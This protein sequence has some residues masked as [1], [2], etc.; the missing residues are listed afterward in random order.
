MWSNDC[1]EK[2]WSSVSRP[3]AWNMK[4]LTNHFLLC[5]TSRSI[6]FCAFEI[7]LS[8][9]YRCSSQTFFSWLVLLQIMPV[10]KIDPKVH[11]KSNELW[12]WTQ[13]IA[14]LY[15]SYTIHR[16]ILFHSKCSE[17]NHYLAKLLRT[18]NYREIT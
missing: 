14:D 17:V 16:H 6:P 12:D 8:P 13:R 18:E 9:S 15:T 4:K 2:T 3:V 7:C 5:N 10:R 11:L 1:L